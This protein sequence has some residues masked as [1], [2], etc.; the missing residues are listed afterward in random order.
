METTQEVTQEVPEATEKKKVRPPETWVV[1]LTFTE[2]LLGTKSANPDAMREFIASKR[3]DGVDEEEIEALPEVEE[4]LQKSTTVFP[5]D[6][7]GNPY[8]L[9]YQV[10]GFFKGACGALRRV[11]GAS[12]HSVGL[13]AYKKEIDGLVF[14]Y[15]RNIELVL[16]DG[17]EIGICERPLRAQ[18]QQGERVSLARS[19][20]VPAGTTATVTIKM[21][22]GHLIPLMEE[23]L[24]YG[25][26]QGMCQWRSSGK[27]RFTYEVLST[28]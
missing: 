22:S 17:G 5:R 19:E 8:L 24:D 23:W 6:G 12:N 11:Q 15:P 3:P 1:K 4:E 27:G 13:K 26:L 25:A 21:L 14:T 28:E 9:D 2:E 7:D 16:P 10:K 18:T 20:T